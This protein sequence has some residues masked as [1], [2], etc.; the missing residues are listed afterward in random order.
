MRHPL[1]SFV[2]SQTVHKRSSGCARFVELVRYAGSAS[3]DRR[4]AVSF[5]RS[6]ATV[7]HTAME[8]TT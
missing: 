5:I 8:Y 2:G 1:Q 6:L 4:Q 7:T 3:V